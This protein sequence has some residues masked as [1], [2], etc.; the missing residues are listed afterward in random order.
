MYEIEYEKVRLIQLCYW[1]LDEKTS[2]SIVLSKNRWKDLQIEYVENLCT[3]GN[4]G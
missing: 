1:K 2:H 3:R 4:N